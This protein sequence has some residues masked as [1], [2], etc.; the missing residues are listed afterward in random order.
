MESEFYKTLVSRYLEKKLSAEELEVF[1]HLLDEGKLDDYLLESMD[2]AIGEQAAPA[3]PVIALKRHPRRYLYRVAVAVAIIAT[4]VLLFRYH[5][6]PVPEQRTAVMQTTPVI[7]GGNNAVLTLGDGKR[8]I[9]NQAPDG[10]LEQ[11]AS[12]SI[13]KEKD[14]LVVFDV[15]GTAAVPRGINTIETP[16]GGIYQVVLPDGSLVWLNNAS[17]IS[18]P[19]RFDGNERRVT[20]NGEAYFEVTHDKTRPFR[21]V[22]DGQEVE[23]L[24]TKFNVNAYKDEAALKTTLLEGSVR[25]R[26][27]QQSG[28]L[29]P[30]F[31]A[32]LKGPAPLV[33]RKADV[34]SVMAWKEGFFQ[35]DR[36]DIPTLMRQLA[37]WYDIDIRYTGAVPK[38]EFVGKIK[39][40]EDI[41][42]VLEILR[43]GKV[44]FRLEGRTLIVE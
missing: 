41:Q 16:K 12:F 27:A 38:D 17:R 26:T 7:P 22:S 40:S 31:Q 43:Y 42:K 36:A 34:E 15:N 30:G 1:F 23:V 25:I 35:F 10:T 4:G 20:I 18:F 11:G 44:K 2:A 29:K 37:R 39:R 33:I 6:R 19:T 21:V 13:R 3:A 5:T 9:L 32:V 8:I 28:L 24:G 14:G